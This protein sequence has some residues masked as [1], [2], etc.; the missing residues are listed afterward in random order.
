MMPTS[1]PGT[2]SRRGF[3]LIE[4][5]VVLLIMGLLAGLVG[6]LVRPDDR[7]VLRVEAE[8][9]SELFDL[10]ATEARLTGIP[11]AW[12]ADAN[13]YRF[14]QLHEDAGRAEAGN[15]SL[16]DSLRARSLPP[17]VV[18]SDLRIEAMRP[19]GGMRLEFGPH[20]SMAYALQ[21][22]LGAARFDI[23]ASP[24][25]EVRIHEAR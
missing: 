23:T 16:R 13:G 6:A 25:G 10:A 17:G 3:T 21:M 11:V 5:L 19:P 7:T 12:A 20:G 15:D 4:L 24:V 22:S 14:W 1:V 2:Y 8:R 9:L 18:I